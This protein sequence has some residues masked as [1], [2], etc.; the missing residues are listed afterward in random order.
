VAVFII[1][2][3]IFGLSVQRVRELGTESPFHHSGSQLINVLYQQL[4]S[5]L[6]LLD[7]KHFPQHSD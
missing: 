6:I 7:S 2:D 4:D 5:M 1:T 3:Y